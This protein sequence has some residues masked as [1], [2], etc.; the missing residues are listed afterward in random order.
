MENAQQHC[1]HTFPHVWFPFSTL[2][3]KPTYDYTGETL[4]YEGGPHAGDLVTNLALGTTLVWLP[5]TAASIGRAAFVKYKFTD[6]RL[7]VA[8]NA[9]WK[10]E[11]LTL[12]TCLHGRGCEH[13]RKRAKC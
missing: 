1:P 2:T 9:P 11:S 13:G 5:L 3:E 6:R 12:F 10:S 4:Y 8:T 7:S